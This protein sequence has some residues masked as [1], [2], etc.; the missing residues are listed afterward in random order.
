[1]NKSESIK[2]IS[3]ALSKFQGEIKNPPKTANNPFFKS[4]YTPLDVIVDTAKPLLQSNGLSYI[5]SCGGDG[6]NISV[7]TLLMHISG[8][9]VE[10]DPLTLKAD[11]QTAQGAGSAIT[12]A[13]RY[14][15][16]AAL[17]LAS[18][19]D[20]DG[21]GASGNKPNPKPEQNNTQS[22]KQSAGSLSQ[23]QLKRVYAIA[24][25][26]GVSAETV[27]A[28]VKKKYSVD[29]SEMTKVQYDTVCAGYEKLVSQKEA[30]HE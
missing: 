19:E 27:K 22:P 15:L 6:L 3:T 30:N 23:A 10:T 20:D 4:K 11:K 16:A 29:V 5:Q 26:A 7:T 25:S 9:W 18:D 17:G 13:R 14:A 8:E 28:Q 24:N 12:Y 1:M 21:N 2:N